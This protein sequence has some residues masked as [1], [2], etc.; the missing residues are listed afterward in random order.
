MTE[1]TLDDQAEVKHTFS[2][3]VVGIGRMS[4]YYFKGIVRFMPHIFEYRDLKAELDR[5]RM[6]A[7]AVSEVRFTPIREIEEKYGFRFSSRLRPRGK[8]Y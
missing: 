8:Y 5:K 1:R 3:W 6:V 2:E 4:S 7:T